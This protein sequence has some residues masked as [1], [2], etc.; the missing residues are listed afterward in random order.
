MTSPVVKWIELEVIMLSEISRS[1][2]I[3]ITFLYAELISLSFLP[4]SLSPPTG[5]HTCETRRETI[6]G[7]E[8]YK[9]GKWGANMN[10]AEYKS[11]KIP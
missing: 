2:K 5:I 6:C 9:G 1:R 7:R 4:L 11:M 8:G 10:K 3:K